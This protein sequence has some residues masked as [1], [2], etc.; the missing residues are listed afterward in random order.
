MMSESNWANAHKESIRGKHE[1]RYDAVEFN[2]YQH[3]NMELLKNSILNKT[4]ECSKYLYFVVHE[5]KM[6][7]IHAPGYQDKIVQY[8]INF[9][10]RDLYEP[11]F[12]HHSYACI[13]NK[14][15]RNAVNALQGFLR[16]VENDNDYTDPYVVSMDVSK[17][18]YTT[19]RDTLKKILN[20]QIRCEDTKWLL[21]KILDGSPEPTGLP[22]GNLTSQLFANILLNEID[23]FVKHD[24]KE[25]YYLRY[26]DDSYII[27]KNREH[28]NQLKEYM[29]EAYS[30]IGLTLN[31]K[32]TVIYPARKGIT[33][34]GFHIT[35][36][37]IRLKT[38]T[39][40]SIQQKLKHTIYELKNDMIT[41][42]L[43][44]QRLNSWM[45]HS[46]SGND[47]SFIL[48][49]SNNYDL[50]KVNKGKLL[51]FDMNI[52]NKL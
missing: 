3:T 51:S 32:K 41:E 9:V 7:T 1:Y 19:D 43:A 17:F 45:Q 27:A 2:E 8:A 40:K 22:L 34:L 39:R 49:I 14:G 5:P 16:K 30:I 13:R 46:L 6:R 4:Y 10:L 20:R 31:P 38:K 42:E 48:W 11:K 21:F 12:I 29:I 26:A 24:L 35:K 52:I 44:N 47:W 28:A 15:N 18:F 25:K 33:G 50:F 36:K 37:H 23:Q